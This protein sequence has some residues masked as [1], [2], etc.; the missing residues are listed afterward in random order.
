M[1]SLEADLGTASK[2]K[3]EIALIVKHGNGTF[4]VVISDIIKQQQVVVKPPTKEIYGKEGVMG[5]TILGDGKPALIIDLLDLY[6]KRLRKESSVN[7][8]N[9]GITA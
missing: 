9:I 4:A 6:L 1:F 5:T 7:I 8:I 3:S 2:S